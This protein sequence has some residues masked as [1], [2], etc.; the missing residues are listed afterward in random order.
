MISPASPG[1]VSRKKKNDTLLSE[2]TSP[3]EVHLTSNGK[4]TSSVLNEAP[5][6]PK[7]VARKNQGEGFLKHSNKV[8]SSGALAEKNIH[9]DGNSAGNLP[10]SPLMLSKKLPNKKILDLYQ[11]L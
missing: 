1:R 11:Y 3:P 4:I 2:V 5:L 7:K 9:G 8:E 6:S 10:I